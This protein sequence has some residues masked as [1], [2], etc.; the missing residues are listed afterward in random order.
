[1]KNTSVLPEPRDSDAQARLFCLPHAGGG[2]AAYYRW[3]KLAPRWLEITPVHLPRREW[4]SQQAE[5]DSLEQL[6]EIGADALSAR[7]DLPY[8]L[9][10]NSMGAVVAFELVRQLRNRGLPLPTLLIAA[11]SH[12]PHASAP[13]PWLHMMPDAQFQQA[14]QDRYDGIPQEI[15]RH[16]EILRLMLPALRADLR[17]METRAH[18]DES[19]L[20]VAIL[21]L[22]GTQD[23]SVGTAELNAWRQHTTGQFAARQFPGGH[24]FLF[25]PASLTEPPVA[26]SLV[27]ERFGRAAGLPAENA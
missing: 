15:L 21:A 13:Q 11:S 16:P 9:L 12:P 22:G 26:L 25:E 4:N 8:A 17:L 23:P 5:F 10:G 19:A 24:F 1:M 27:I 6:V 14:V 2:A 20:D 3:S 18:R 7:L